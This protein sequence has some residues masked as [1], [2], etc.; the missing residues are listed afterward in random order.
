MH[1]VETMF[2]VREVPWH[3]LGVNVDEAPTSLEAIRL[4]EL[5]W[6]VVQEPIFA[7]SGV[8]VPNVY[9]N[10]RDTDNSVLGLVSKRYNI[11]QNKDAFDFVDNLVGGE[12][13]YETAGSLSNGKMIWLLAQLPTEKILD[14]EVKN[15]LIFSN[16]HNGKSSIKVSCTPIRV[17]CN[18]TLNLALGLSKRIWSVPHVGDLDVK[19]DIARSSLELNEIYMKRMKQFFLD[20]FKEKFNNVDSYA[21]NIFS[22]NELEGKSQNNAILLRDDFLKRY[23]DAPDISNYRGTKTGVIMALTDHRSHRPVLRET[24]TSDEIYMKQAI[25]G[26]TWLNNAMSILEAA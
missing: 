13:R 2:Y 7:Q 4:A 15:Y 24:N 6:T 14:D 26:D 12:V 3:G 20:N 21:D 8:K 19:L 9:A 1:N 17:V 18:N 16:S 10:I 5:D 23:N 11:V 22:I 25:L